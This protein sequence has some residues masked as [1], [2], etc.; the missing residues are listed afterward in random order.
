MADSRKLSV[1]KALTTHFEAINPTNDDPA[2]APATPYAIDLRGKVSRGRLTFGPDELVDGPILSILEA[3]KAIEPVSV[4][5]GLVRK[6]SWQLL[7]Q[8]FVQDEKENP[9]DPAYDLLALVEMRLARVVQRDKNGDG[10]YPDEYR[11]DGLIDSLAIGDGIVRPS[12]PQVSPTAFFYLPVVV[13]LATD[14]RN[15]YAA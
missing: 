8:G 14:L 3:T 11:L 5:E 9:T 13:V 15:P 7:I 1:M 10:A 2:L 6:S 12:D 4:A